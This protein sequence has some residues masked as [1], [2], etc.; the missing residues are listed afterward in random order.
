[1]VRA[2]DLSATDVLHSPCQK[3]R[4]VAWPK[5]LPFL[6]HLC[7]TGSVFNLPVP[8]WG[9]SYCMFEIHLHKSTLDATHLWEMACY[10]PDFGINQIFDVLVGT[11][12][13]L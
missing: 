5:R 7:L 13:C 2:F 12:V 1:M 11:T 6:A 10:T 9:L 3:H 4:R 8:V